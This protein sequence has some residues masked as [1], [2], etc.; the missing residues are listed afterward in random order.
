M[1]RNASAGDS[2]EQNEDMPIVEEALRVP[3]KQ[4]LAIHLP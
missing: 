4:T 1:T 3:A 2:V